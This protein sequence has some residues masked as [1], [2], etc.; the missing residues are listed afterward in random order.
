MCVPAEL[1]AKADNEAKADD[2]GD[3]DGEGSTTTAENLSSE[4]DMASWPVF[5]RCKGHFYELVSSH[6]IQPVPAYD[7]N[8]NLIPPSQ[9]ESKLKGALVEVHRLFITIASSHRSA[10]F[11]TRSCENSLSSLCPQPCQPTYSNVAA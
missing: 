4:Y 2:E 10:T 3:D 11:S 6:N 7:E 5:D 1:A 8:H 9:Y